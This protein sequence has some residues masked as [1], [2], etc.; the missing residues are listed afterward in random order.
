MQLVQ[1]LR[2]LDG[3][4][5]EV[6]ILI[7]EDEAALGEIASLGEGDL[8]HINGVLHGAELPPRE[9]V[10]EK[11]DFGVGVADGGDQ[12]VGVA[13]V[14]GRERVGAHRLEFRLRDDA[15]IV[16]EHLGTRA[17]ARAAPERGHG[18]AERGVGQRV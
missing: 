10:E 17:W 2:P 12:V 18:G 11:H 6:A 5:V 8:L 4:E 15:P 1:L 7:D 9:W 3:R 14:D 13:D 16:I